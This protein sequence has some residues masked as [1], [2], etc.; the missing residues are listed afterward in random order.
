[1]DMIQTDVSDHAL[2]TAI[3][4]NMCAFFRYLGGSFPEDYFEDEKFARWHLPVAH[5]W[6]NGV[7]CS[8]LPENSDTAFIED[9]I[10]Y[11]RAQNVSSFTWWMEPHLKCAD[12][13]P[14]LSPY[15]FGLSKDTPGMAVDIQPMDEPAQVLNGLEIREVVDAASLRIWAHIFTAGYGLPAKWESS[16]HGLEQRLGLDLPIRNFLAYW[17]GEPAATSTL[18]LGAGVAGIYNVATMPGARGQGIGGAMTLRPL[19]EAREMGYRIGILQSS[20]MGFNVYQ[21]LGFRH[22]CQIEYFHLTL[23]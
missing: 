14:I 11:F 6:F 13:E 16:V 21:K 12:W 9:S 8:Q 5:P 10:Q 2:I 15:G 23:T 18:F 1:M 20:D 4:A 22:L 7:L 3:R 19:Q 17:N